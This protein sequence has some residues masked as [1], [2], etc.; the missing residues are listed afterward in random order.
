ELAGVAATAGPA[1][2]DTATTRVVGGGPVAIAARPFQVAL[3]DPAPDGAAASPYAG[4]FCG[5]TIVDATHVVT[6][7]HCVFDSTTGQARDVSHVRVLAGTAHLRDG[8]EPEATTARDVAVTQMVVRPGFTIDNLDGDAAVLTLAEPLYAG[9]PKIDGTTPIAPI[10]LITATESAQYVDPE[11]SAAVKLSG[12]GDRTAQSGSGVGTILGTTN[13]YPR[14]LQIAT[15]HI[16]KRSTCQSAYTGS[17]ANVN[18]RVL[19]AGE[20]QGG[21]DSCQGDSGGP[22]T[23]DIGGTPVLAGIVSLGIGCAQPGRPGLYTRVGESSVN[24][25]LRAAT[26]IPDTTPTPPVTPRSTADSARPTMRLAS[27][28]CTPTRCVT[29][30]RVADATPSA[31]IRKI[32]ATLRWTAAGR[33]RSKTVKAR[34]TSSG[35]GTIVTSGLVRGRR[36]TLTLRA[37]DKAGHA[38]RKAKVYALTPGR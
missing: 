17:G 30:V 14:D 9:S 11:G 5:G 23:V 26:N 19:C 21:V 22:L 10:A 18:D 16:F 24:S 15:T 32:T 36:Y 13:D 29:R 3:Y 7:G 35:K 33:K 6:A 34:T 12:W 8:A 4:Q 25:F 31:G 27:R 37:T 1:A 38:Q 2:A 28:R 20:P